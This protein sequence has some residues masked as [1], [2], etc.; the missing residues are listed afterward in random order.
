MEKKFSLKQVLAIAAFCV[1]ATV[2]ITAIAFQFVITPE[3]A[4]VIPGESTAEQ[5]QDLND[6][7]KEI[8]TLVDKYYIGEFDS[9]MLAHH[10]CAGYVA[11]LNDKYSGYVTPEN[12]AES[13][14]SLYGVNS[15]MG[16]QISLHPDNKT[17]FVLEVHDGSPAMTAGIERGD[18]IIAVDDKQVSEFGY[19]ETLTYIKK[20]PS[21]TTIKVKAIRNGEE[22][23]FDVTLKH[24]ID[25]SVFYRMIGDKGYIQITGFND[26]SPEQFKTAVDTLT[27]EGATALI[28]DLR[29]NGGGT[30]NAAYKMLDYCIP[31]GLAIRVKYKDDN[32]NEVYM[33]D[34]NEVNL[35]IVCLTDENTASA[36]ELFTQGLKDYNKAVT[37]GRLTYGKGVV[38][39]TFTLSDGSLVRF[40]IGEYYTKNGVCL[41]GIGVKPDVEVTFTDE[42][43]KYRII[44]GIEKDKD[45]I[46]AV[47]YLE[48]QPS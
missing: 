6:K 1:A 27:E 11:G 29:G 28:I 3:T 31:E 35:P 22:K 34:A 24:Y 14:N 5:Q 12:A 41:D 38:Q 36:S 13:L 30:L 17:I 45:F 9:E 33:S 8:R 21:E 46:A 42:E 7:L 2:A 20:L 44:N 47:E 25:Q 39:R 15:G 10:I 40:T 43:L 26:R 4:N 19:A 32:M 18:E 48:N 37:V 16:I 23:E